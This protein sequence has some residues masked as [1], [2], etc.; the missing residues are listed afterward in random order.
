VRYVTNPTQGASEQ[1]VINVNT[2][3][4]LSAI[5]KGTRTYEFRGRNLPRVPGQLITLYRVD[6]TGKEIRTSN[7]KTDSSGIY[8][9]TRKFTGNGTFH[10]LVRTS[11]TNDNAPGHSNTIT[12]NIH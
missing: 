11:K 9:V 4:S 5:R 7:L 2:V 8:T 6:N 3:L 12:T 10:F 1:V